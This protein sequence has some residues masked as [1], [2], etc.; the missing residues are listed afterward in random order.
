MLWPIN[1]VDEFRIKLYLR[2]TNL[3]TA[4]QNIIKSED[5]NYS[6]TGQCN[7]KFP[8]INKLQHYKP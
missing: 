2:L 3:T 7:V 6:Y 1:L 5:R 8:S 4:G